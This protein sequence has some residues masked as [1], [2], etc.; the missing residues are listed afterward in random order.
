MYV[1]YFAVW[2]KLTEHF[3]STIIKI[4]KIKIKNDSS[5]PEGHNGS[6][7]SDSDLQMC[8]LL[9]TLCLLKKKGG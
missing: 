6:L 8:S 1:C 7:K 3:Q 9:P 5:P 4:Q 2:Q